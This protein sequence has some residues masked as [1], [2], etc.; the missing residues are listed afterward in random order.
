MKAYLIPRYKNI[1]SG[2]FLKYFDFRTPIDFDGFIDQIEKL[3][4]ENPEKAKKMAFEAYDYD[5]DGQIQDLDLFS[6]MKV[7][8]QDEELFSKSFTP[9]LL[10]I[11][12]IIE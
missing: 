9:D 8:S 12:R 1:I 11:E 7:F 2:R 10:A 4:N 5:D 3:L 6:T